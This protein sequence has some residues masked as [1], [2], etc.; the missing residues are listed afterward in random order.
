MVFKF[1]SCVSKKGKHCGL[2][3][4]INNLRLYIT[5]ETCMGMYCHKKLTNK[6]KLSIRMFF[7]EHTNKIQQQPQKLGEVMETY[8]SDGATL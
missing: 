7:N 8:I 5:M 2:V 4:T 3:K 6:I 1:D